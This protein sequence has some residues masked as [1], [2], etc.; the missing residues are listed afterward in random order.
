MARVRSSAI[1]I[2]ALNLVLQPHTPITYIEMLQKMARYKFDAQVHGDNA[3]LL[4]TCRY[5]DPSNPLEGVR[6]DIY[7]FLK[8]DSSDAWFNTENMDEATEDEVAEI[9]IPE[10]LKPHFKRFQYI[11]FPEGHRFYFISS[12]PKQSLSPRLVKI[13]FESVFR[14]EEFAEFGSLNV[15]IQPDPNRLDELFAMRNIS[16]IKMEIA[17]PNPDDLEE[18]EAEIL[19]RLN[20]INAKTEKI[21]FLAANT[22]GLRPDG[23]LR[24]LA[25]VANDNGFVYAE[26]KS[27]DGLKTYMSTKDMPLHITAKYNPNISS[28]FDALYDKVVEIHREITG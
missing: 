1:H 5:L 6:G 11:F 2:G 16:V 26:G 3:L 17:R 28:E 15:T 24:V 10:N 27:A 18:A 22:E 12:K 25:E 4:G 8:L 7:K 19:E 23:E 14:R 9:N 20:R 13:F 21:E